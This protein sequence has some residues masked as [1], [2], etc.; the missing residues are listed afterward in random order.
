M[1]R[2]EVNV[3]QMIEKKHQKNI[4]RNIWR[5]DENCEEENNDTAVFENCLS[6][7]AANLSAFE[8]NKGFHE[9]V[10]NDNDQKLNPLEVEEDR[11]HTAE[12]DQCSL[13]VGKLCDVDG[14]DTDYFDS[15]DEHWESL[16]R[17]QIDTEYC[18]RCL[19]HHHPSVTMGKEQDISCKV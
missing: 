15:E 2:S 12:E 3:T 10:D 1:S 9:N 18:P 17:Q 4:L 7:I 14:D 19:R 13:D 5:N 16:K 6:G 11:K 8:L